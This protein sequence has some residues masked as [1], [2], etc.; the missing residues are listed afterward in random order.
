MSRLD[1]ARAGMIVVRDLPTIRKLSRELASVVTVPV[2]VT[3]DPSIRKQ[4]LLADGL[5][6]H[7]IDVRLARERESDAAGTSD[8]GTYRWR[9]TNDGP[10]E[11]FQREIS[12]MIDSGV[13]S[14]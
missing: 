8:G 3:A 6:E 13:T 4:R 1:G 12:R 5:D 14:S 7:E 2:L 11:E 9:L 10:L